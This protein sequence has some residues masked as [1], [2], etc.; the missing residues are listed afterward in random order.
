MLRWSLLILK[1]GELFWQSAFRQHLPLL[2]V[3]VRN[4]NR[5]M[6]QTG[7]LPRFLL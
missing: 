3:A 6:E 1:L 4:A 7:L 5:P 2:R